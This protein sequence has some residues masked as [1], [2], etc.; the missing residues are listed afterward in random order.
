MNQQLDNFFREKLHDHQKSAPAGAWNRIASALDKPQRTFVWWKIAASIVLVCL[1]AYIFWN[2]NSHPSTPSL[3]QV[4]AVEPA[5]KK[6]DDIEKV[7]PTEQPDQ[8][9]ANN[10]SLT[11]SA[12]ERQPK[13]PSVNT[14]HSRKLVA[15]AP[16]ETPVVSEEETTSEEI[17]SSP[18]K[19]VQH[20]EQSPSSQKPSSITLTYTVEETNKY[21]DKNG[22]AEA[23]S[24]GKKSSTLKKL[25]KKAND[26]KSNQDPF[27]D[28]RER[29]NEILAL[30][31]KNEKRG[32]NK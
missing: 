6:A 11:P 31:F 16:T 32:Q 21:L 8:K 17:I 4:K 24:T 10:N 28:L 2:K 7:L 1:T 23:T 15:V 14:I 19:T 26:L 27:G 3:S 25:L 22:L 30:N 20:A 5:V 13:K 9:M 18:D 29:K 12:V